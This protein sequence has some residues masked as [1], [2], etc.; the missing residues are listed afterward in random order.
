MKIETKKKICF[1]TGHV[2]LDVSLKLV[3]NSR[4][5]KTAQTGKMG[6]KRKRFME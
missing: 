1:C 3:S 4:Q 2:A 5:Q 6:E